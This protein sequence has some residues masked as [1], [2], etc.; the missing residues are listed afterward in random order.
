MQGSAFSRF[1]GV[2]ILLYASVVQGASPVTHRLFRPSLDVFARGG[3]GF[4]GG[5]RGGGQGFRGQ[6]GF[7]RGGGQADAPLTK[8]FDS[9]RNG[10]LDEAERRVAR[11]YGESEGLSR[12]RGFGRRGNFG[13]VPE[14]GERL[15]P[16]AVQPYPSTVFYNTNTLR[17]LF[18]DFEND[19][20]ER[21]LMAFK[22]TDVDVPAT[23]TIDGKAYEDVGVQFHGNSS[24]SGVPIGFKHSMRLALDFVHDG[25]DVSSYNTLLLLNAHEDP[26][27]VRTVLAMQIARDYYPAPKANLVRVVIN[28]ENWGIYV[29]QQQF[30][31]D[32][33]RE[34]FGATGGTRWKVNGNPG[35]RGT[36][37]VYLGDDVDAYKRA[38]EI[39]T[40]DDPAAW[41][42][43]IQLTQILNHTPPERL[44]RELAPYLDI[45][46]ALRFLAVDI[47]LANSD[48]YWTRASDYSLYL[49]PSGKFHVLPYDVNSTFTIGGGRGGGRGGSVDLHPLQAEGDPSKALASRLLAVPALRMRYLG[50]VRDIATKWLDWPRLG[51]VVTKYQSLIR[52]DVL[53][54]GRKLASS[55]AFDESASEL[56]YFVSERRD[57]LLATADPLR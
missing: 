40:K 45:D 37:L 57:F 55:E 16:A 22:N 9:N 49:D 14:P 28:G 47:A 1:A 36:G 7:G 50:Y 35:G 41:K 17:T 18:L 38:Y 53:A 25:Q 44:E 30:N 15:S 19:D 33:T 48:G 51:P 10:R 29:N 23:L 43:L 12:G 39:K 32:M 34:L 54:D 26:S 8:Q 24:F 6:G 5:G 11:L 13:V 56:R 2:A 52:Q 27:F 46:G 4:P 31:K 20:W 21:E 3:P 42:A